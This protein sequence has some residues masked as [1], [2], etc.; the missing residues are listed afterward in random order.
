MQT[1]GGLGLFAILLLMAIGLAI[2]FGLMG[3]IN[4]AHGEIMAMGAYATFLTGAVIESIAPSL[5]PVA[6]FFELAIAFCVTFIFGYLLEISFIRFFYKRP[7]DTLL[8]TWGFSLVLQ[9]SYRAIFGAQEVSV[10]TP[11]WLIGAW[12]PVVG[13]DLPL[14]RIFIIALTMAVM[15]IV[16]YSLFRTQWGLKVRA[17]TQNRPM[18][19]AAGI[20][21]RKIDSLT[22]AFGSGLAGIAGS[23]F[24]LIGSTNPGTGQLYIVDAFIVVVFG[25]V[26][27]I[28]GTVASAFVIAESQTAFEYILSPSIAKITVLLLVV[29]IL[30]FRPKG[31]FALKMRS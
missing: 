21:T 11:K 15:A 6:I 30:Y 23:V 27:S 24:T 26:E 12:Q 25:G 22:F 16:Y 1:F 2:I 14:N 7:L 8:A 10:A 9:Q 29:V 20:N 18:S 4:M 5:L 19:Q 31:L 3:V 13:I 28:L 17:V